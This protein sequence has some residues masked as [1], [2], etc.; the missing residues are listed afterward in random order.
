MA[1]LQHSLLRP[2]RS[3]LVTGASGFLGIHLCR[4]LARH[5]WKCHALALTAADA[6]TVAPFVDKVHVGDVRQPKTLAPALSDCTHVIHAAAAIKASRV[7]DFFE[8]N[9]EGTRNLLTV[10]GQVAPSLER[11][12]HISSLAA[13]GPLWAGTSG[14][15]GSRSHPVTAYGWSK[16]L[17]EEEVRL[18]R[19]TIPAT[20]LRPPPM[21]GP[22][23]R[24]TLSIFQMLDKGISVSPGAG[25]SVLP[26]LHVADCATAVV[27][28]LDTELPSGT[29]LELNGPD[30]LTYDDV[31]TTIAAALNKQPWLKLRAPKL[32]VRLAGNMAD[33]VGKARAEILP[34]NGDKVAEVLAPD[35]TVDDSAAR[36]HLRWQPIVGFQ[37]GV[38]DTLHWYRRHEWL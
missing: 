36:S 24:G 16:R 12:I 13:R 5:G 9:H 20:I 38:R 10:M 30:R 27:K 26:V 7:A 2:R 1:M 11:L 35:W 15:P 17:G 18:R 23:D 21:Y 8:V 14:R 19:H 29:S 4:E 25:M 28:A 34:F 3:V 6:D 22:G 31:L 33:W 32:I 37:Q